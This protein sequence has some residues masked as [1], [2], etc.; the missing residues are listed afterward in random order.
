METIG[1]LYNKEAGLNKDDIKE[2]FGDSLKTNYKIFEPYITHVR[3][4]NR[5]DKMYREFQDMYEDI[6]K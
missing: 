5:C 3:S 6:Y 4:L 1:Y 2:L